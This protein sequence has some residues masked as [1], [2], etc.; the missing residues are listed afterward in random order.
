M[1]RGT[2]PVAQ[3]AGMVNAIIIAVNSKNVLS[4]TRCMMVSLMDKEMNMA[5]QQQRRPVRQHALQQE[6]SDRN[7]A[8][9]QQ[10]LGVKMQAKC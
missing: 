10:K 5:T 3:V 9:G 7:D 4:R 1:T 8:D 2:D 6:S